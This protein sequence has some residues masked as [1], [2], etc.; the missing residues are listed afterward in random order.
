VKPCVVQFTIDAGGDPKGVL[1]T[2][3]NI[4]AIAEIAASSLDVGEEDRILT[5]VPLFYAYG[6][7]FG[8]LLAMKYG[9]TLFLE[10]EVSPNRVQKI[11]RE[12]EIDLLPGTPTLYSSLAR[13]P[14]SKGLSAKKARFLASGSPMNETM[15][16]RFY[17][18]YGI[19][20]LSCHHAAETGPVTV[21]RRGNAPLSVGKPF[22]GVELRVTDEQDAPVGAGKRG[23]VWVRSK[24]VAPFAVGPTT[25]TAPRSVGVPVGGMS[26]DGWFRTGDIGFLDKGGRL[27]LQ[28]RE[29]DLVQ[30]DGK[31]IALGEVE[32]CLEAFPKVKAAEV[33]VVT[34]P[35][36]GPMVVAHV[37]PAAG[38]FDPEE[39]I[40]HCARNLA[41]YKVPRRIEFCDRLPG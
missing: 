10:D 28:G 21:D 7:D 31:R 35:L 3:E 12:H 4:Q 6:F 23:R 34:D 27:Y 2:E 17:E 1:R 15:A 25:V 13:L 19:R 37:V 41:P 38:A 30:V 22:E 16:D 5:T 9:G 29:D 33:R 39:A 18:R 32:G 24:A 36:G 26:R 11:L 20:I 8:L 14:V 40:D